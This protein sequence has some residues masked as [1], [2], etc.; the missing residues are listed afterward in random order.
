M[1]QPDGIRGSEF[2][3]TCAEL[4]ETN[5]ECRVMT[6]GLAMDDSYWSPRPGVHIQAQQPQ[7]R[8]VVH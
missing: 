5:G 1:Y 7:D 8:Y 6:G 3:A 4:I 2:A